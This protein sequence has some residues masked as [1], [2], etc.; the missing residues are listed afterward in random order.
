M[1]RGRRVLVVSNFVYTV[2]SGLYLTAG[3]LYFTEAVGLPAG[4]VGLGLGIA[5]CVSLAVG[6]AAGHLADRRGARGVY[7]TTL[8]VQAL[9]TAAFLLADGFWPFV[10]A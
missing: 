8:V 4:Q 3:V 1:S 6:I 2:G 5:G 7:L 10:L 9:A